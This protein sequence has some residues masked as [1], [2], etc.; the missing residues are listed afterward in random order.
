MTAEASNQFLYELAKKQMRM[1]Y[2]VAQ[3]GVYVTALKDSIFVRSE[4]IQL[5][6]MHPLDLKKDVNTFE[7]SKYALMN[8]EK[9]GQQKAVVYAHSLQLKRAATDLRRIAAS[10]PQWKDFEFI[11][12]EI[13]NTPFPKH[14]TQW[15][16]RNKIVY[17]A[18]ELY[19]SRVRDSWIN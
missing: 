6:R 15:R 16:T 8:M 3:E 10:N 13:P 12:P 9:L 11:T 19:F 1:K 18:I 5:I 17:R 4:A 2:L 7:S 14:S